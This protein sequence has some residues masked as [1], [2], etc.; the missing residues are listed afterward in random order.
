MTGFRRTAALAACVLLVGC[1]TSTP[2][3]TTA[4]ATAIASVN[5][6]WGKAYNGGDA[7][8]LVALYTEDAAVNPPGT[9]QVRGH[10]AMQEFFAK[11][12]TGAK[13]AGITMNLNPQ[14]DS[15]ISGDVAWESGTFTATD[16]S[17]ATVD[18]GKYITV[19][20]KKDGKWLIVRDTWNSDNPPPAPAPAAEA[21]TKK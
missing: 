13:A 6:A 18:A 14:K 21:V 12:T 9:P 10:A 20:Q 4:D 7:A 16:K 8:G 17:G 11:D 3:D 2:A 19:F 5:E 15:G 1:V